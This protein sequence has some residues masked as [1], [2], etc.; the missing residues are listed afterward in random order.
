[1]TLRDHIDARKR[2]AHEVLDQVKAGI[3]VEIWRIR[4]ALAVLGDVE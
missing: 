2:Q 3:Q 1:M 4:W